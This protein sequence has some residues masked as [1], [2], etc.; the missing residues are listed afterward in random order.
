MTNTESSTQP[1]KY[2]WAS[3]WR[4]HVNL[5]RE[6]APEEFTVFVRAVSREDAHAAMGRVILSIFP[7]A[8]LEYAYYNLTSA[9]ELVEQGVSRLENDRLFETAWQ[10]NRVAGWVDKPVFAVPDAAEL[11]E[12]WMTAR[13]LKVSPE[14][15]SEPLALNP[16]ADASEAAVK[17]FLR[18]VCSIGADSQEERNEIDEQLEAL[19]PALIELRDAGHIK[20]NMAVAARYGTLDGFMRLAA[21]ERLTPPSRYRC[22]AIQ[23]RL[24]AKSLKSLFRL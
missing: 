20:L 11:F 10:G 18:Q 23:N 22:S 17:E 16:L 3:L 12:A 9:R 21:D 2:G 4:A 14:H 1:L 15:P 5:P 6:I 8:D 19:V 7:S 24:L 13:S